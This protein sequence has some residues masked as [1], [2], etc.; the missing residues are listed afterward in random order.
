MWHLSYEWI[1][2]TH[3]R[4][5]VTTLHFSLFPEQGRQPRALQ[6]PLVWSYLQ[7]FLLKLW[8]RRLSSFLTKQPQQWRGKKQ[9]S[10]SV[11]SGQSG[12]Q[13][14][15]RD[16]GRRIYN[17]TISEK[18]D[19]RKVSGKLFVRRFCCCNHIMLGSVLVILWSSL[20]FISA[21]SYSTVVCW[22]NF[23]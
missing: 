12:L 23:V 5:Y 4:H 22:F 3:A 9:L 20:L 18:T 17:T 8:G 6:K 1:N 16:T 7:P 14:N 11:K 21:L 19:N 15:G 13:S 2:V 10:W